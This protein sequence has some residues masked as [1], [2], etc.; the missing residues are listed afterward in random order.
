MAPQAGQV[1]FM[2]AMLLTARET[3]GARIL[4]RSGG[5][6]NLP[7]GRGLITP[8][9]NM[10]GLAQQPCRVGLA[11]S[12]IDLQRIA[13]AVVQRA[14]DQGS[15]VPAEVC[16]ELTRAGL[17]DGL[18][19]D[20]LALARASLSYRQGRYYYVPAVSDRVR[21]EQ[22]Q[23]AGLQQVIL[24]LIR[25]YRNSARGSVERRE[26]DRIDFVQPIRVRTE[27]GQEFTL[28]SRDLSPTGIRLVGTRRLLGQKV[29][30]SLPAGNGGGPCCFLV[31]VLWTCAV[32][33]DLFENGGE[34]LE[35]VE[36]RK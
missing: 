35:V 14:R 10:L 3:G 11:M 7:A 19:K 25:Q 4:P 36:E 9:E 1:V 5:D 29:R 13:D 2:A 16:E 24:R 26:Q 30:V 8:A 17:P 20:V 23:Q 18:W 34:F 33:D 6:L 12:E 32:G 15:V 28:L 21:Q 27:D 22:R 31:R